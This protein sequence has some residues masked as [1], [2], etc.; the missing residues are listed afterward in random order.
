MGCGMN[1]INTAELL[2]EA[3]AE[4][5]N[6]A[7]KSLMLQYL[8]LLEEDH[9]LTHFHLMSDKSNIVLENLGMRW[10][11]PGFNDIRLMLAYCFRTGFISES[12]RIKKNINT[13]L[14]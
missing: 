3:F 6:A 4:Q 1:L 8:P 2:E 11:K 12:Y 14:T 5:G 13:Q 10:Q 9:H 7:W